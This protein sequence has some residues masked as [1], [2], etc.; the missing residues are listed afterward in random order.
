VYP[1]DPKAYMGEVLAPCIDSGEL[2]GVFERYLLEPDDD[3]QGAIESRLEEVRRY[4]DKKTEH[5]RYGAMVRLLKEKH[6]EAKLTLNDP[7]ERAR[8]A[9]EVRG[10]QRERAEESARATKEWDELLEQLVR[11]GNGLEPA[12]RARLEKMAAS[13]GIPAERTKAKLEAVPD[14]PE[15]DV[16]SSGQ[17]QVIARALNNLALDVGEPRRGL[18]LFHALELEL[19]DDVEVVAERHARQ[20]EE[21]RVRPHGNSKANWESVLS[22]VKIHL[23]E[24][25]PRA[26]VQGLLGEVREGLELKA[27]KAVADDGEIDEVEAEQLLREALA[28]GLT[29]ELAQRV[30]AELARE[31][32]AGLR[33]GAA[34]DFV[35]CPSCNFPHP[36]EAGE[37]R[38]RECGTPLFVDCPRGCGR[39]NDA[40]AARCAGCGADLHR[41]S[42]ATR[43]LTR[44]PELLEAGRPAKA[45]EER[46]AAARV[47]DPAHPDLEQ[48]SRQVAAALTEAKQGWAAV[49]AARDER[50][51]YAARQLLQELERS[52]KDFPGPSGELPS[53]AIEAVRERIAEAERLVARARGLG[54]AERESALV[55]A[56]TV[57][58]DCEEADRELDKL[59][60]L[61]PAEVRAEVR[62]NSVAV[63]W[64]GSES[65][66]VRYLVTRVAENGVKATVGEADGVEVDDGKAVA[67]TTVRYAVEA[68]RGRARSSA[69]LGEPITVAYEVE[70]L[71]VIGGDGEV[72]LSWR[73][74][75]GESR[76][77]VTRR[78]EGAEAVTNV[79]PQGAG[80]RDQDVANG[81]RYTYLVQVE[82]PGPGGK[83]LRTA[84]ISSF[85]Q[86]VEK[87]LPL[88][89][90]ELRSGPEG[91]VFSFE[92]PKA[93]A[94]SILRCA[95]DPKLEPGAELDLARLGEVGVALQPSGPE[96]IDPEPPAGRC[97]YQAISIAA[98]VAVA[99]VAVSHVSLPPCT[100]V[101]AVAN[102][103]V[104]KVTWSWPREVTLAR[105][106]WRHDSQP[107]GPRDPDAHSLHLRLGE[108]RDGGGCT[109]ELGEERALFVAVF[110]AMRDGAEIACGGDGGRASRAT[111]RSERKT[112]LR[113]AVRRSGLLQKRLE[114][115]VDDPAG[116]ELPE[117]VLVGREGD[118]LPRSSSEG[119]VLARLGGADGPRASTVELRGLS[120][121]LA[122]K[123]FLNSNSAGSSFVLLDPMADDL[124][125]G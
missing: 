83:V 108:Y 70:G 92:R 121:P 89:N 15:P 61:P 56:V 79:P 97:F 120:R 53:E 20:V 30:V 23:L 25:D 117:L 16:L 26:Y 39:R 19:S 64:R 17:L 44:L 68:V 21:N 104:A 105:V 66:S 116:G 3:D 125:I 24:S 80:A 38:C 55:E 123:L 2:P 54:G 74:R 50:R 14:A 1:F 42:A 35:A 71:R 22:L 106:V 85:A 107:Q 72:N 40:T 60:P 78:E 49:A 41:Y 113:Y 95:E 63:S 93:G 67:G 103:R 47:L 43:A 52:A 4:W 91:I 11:A 6:A 36:R 115:E 110:P 48:V 28:Q 81:R 122:V 9:E 118:L 99:G 114:V 73:P 62:D 94:V 29:T 27:M 112:E 88:R 119:T 8:A 33:V 7:R 45:E 124:L 13:K 57:A 75:A 34:V 37:D 31:H 58:V 32:G 100:N 76:V 69:A 111:L 82:Y 102:G 65:R 96:V 46:A 109:I 98:G 86:P 12:Q 90:L 10:R 59:P 51:Q 84:G 5:P 87:P 18:S 77:I 101:R